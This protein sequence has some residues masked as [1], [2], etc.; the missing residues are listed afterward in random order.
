MSVYSQIYLA[1]NASTIILLPKK[2]IIYSN[3]GSN[4][5]LP[6]LPASYSLTLPFIA[7]P[8]GGWG[9]KPIAEETGYPSGAGQ[10]HIPLFRDAVA[11]IS[12]QWLIAA[13]AKSNLPYCLTIWSVQPGLEN[14]DLRT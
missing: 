6:L 4:V 7:R 10:M 9:H 11:R 5:A 3:L 1:N 14:L 13:G 8:R 12:V 2:I